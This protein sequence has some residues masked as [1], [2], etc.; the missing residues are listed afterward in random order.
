MNNVNPKATSQNIPA[1]QPRPS[2][3]PR[4]TP[5]KT[6]PKPYVKPE[7]IAA[8]PNPTT[9]SGSQQTFGVFDA[10]NLSN[11]EAGVFDEP[12][13]PRVQIDQNSE[14]FYGVFEEVK[15]RK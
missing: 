15:L 12:R 10:V 5:P 9:N 14:K 4:P 6:T 7:P 13:V 1:P 11:P 3:K 2:F 8:V